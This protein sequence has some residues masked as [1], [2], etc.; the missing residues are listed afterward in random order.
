MQCPVTGCLTLNRYE[1][2]KKYG[3]WRKHLT[4]DDD[5]DEFKADFMDKLERKHKNQDDSDDE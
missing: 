1:C 4:A 5:E 3:H 2:F